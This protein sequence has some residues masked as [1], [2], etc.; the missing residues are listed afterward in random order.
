MVVLNVFRVFVEWFWNEWN[1]NLGYVCFEIGL[2]V[3]WN[4][5]IVCCFLIS[6]FVEGN[7]F[8]QSEN[9]VIE[10]A[11]KMVVEIVLLTDCW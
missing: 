9:N 2:I 11:L 3:L 5:D 10:V 8:E 1:V 4:L 7:R 6:W